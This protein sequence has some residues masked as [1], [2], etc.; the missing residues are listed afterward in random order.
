M[1]ILLAVI[2]GFKRDKLSLLRIHYH[3]CL[4]TVRIPFALQQLLL[5]KFWRCGPTGCSVE[6]NYGNDVSQGHV[7]TRDSAAADAA[8]SRCSLPVQRR[9]VSYYD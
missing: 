1:H 5:S 7:V 2:G 3:C 6:G 8:S 4:L 9:P